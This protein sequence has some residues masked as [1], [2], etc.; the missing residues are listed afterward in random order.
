MKR[1]AIIA[2]VLE[3]PQATQQSFNELVAEYKDIIRGRMGIP[4]E[5]EKVSVVSLVVVGTN[6][7][8]NALTGKLGKLNDV[9]V[10]TAFSKKDYD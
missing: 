6:D 9:Y 4:F 8:I 3:D 2:A 5:K 1:I 7:E 10:K